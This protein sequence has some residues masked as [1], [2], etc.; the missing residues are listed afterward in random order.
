MHRIALH[1]QG[2][3]RLALPDL[4]M[5]VSFCLASLCGVHCCCAACTSL[6]SL[7]LPAPCH[8]GSFGA[9]I[10]YGHCPPVACPLAANGWRL[11]QP[12]VEPPLPTQL[13]R[14]HLCRAHLSSCLGCPL[15]SGGSGAS[16]TGAA[17]SCCVAARPSARPPG[18]H[19]SRHAGAKHAAPDMWHRCIRLCGAC[20]VPQW[21]G[22]CAWP[23][24]FSIG[25][26]LVPSTRQ[27]CILEQ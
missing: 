8:G 21:P 17:C 24:S 23:L 4:V 26:P 20:C 1:T 19:G 18:Q 22:L 10:W 9:C 6:A 27:P 7:P 15:L 16:P 3:P 25:L 5:L 2:R 13:C 12:V 11:L 14:A